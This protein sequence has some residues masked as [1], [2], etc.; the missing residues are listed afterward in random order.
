[1]KGEQG[2]Q[3][4]EEKQEDDSKQQEELV[5][6]SV[7]DMW[8][9]QMNASV[10]GVER[11]GEVGYLVWLKKWGSAGQVELCRFIGLAGQHKQFYL[12]PERWKFF[13]SCTCQKDM[14]IF[15]MPHISG[16]SGFRETSYK[17]A[18]TQ[19]REMEVGLR[20]SRK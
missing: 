19:A 12:Y 11:Q 8:N 15:V 16:C 6:A 7:L 14:I 4:S 18:L 1:M 3:L 17:A 13:T 2:D 9:R 20:V 5:E 10:A